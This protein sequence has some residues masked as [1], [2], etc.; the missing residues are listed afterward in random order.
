MPASSSELKIVRW[1][2]S[3]TGSPVGKSLAMWPNE[4]PARRKNRFGNVW[5]S[6]DAK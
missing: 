1:A 3:F 4:V 5:L 2:K 6:T